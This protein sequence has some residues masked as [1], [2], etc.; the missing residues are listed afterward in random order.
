MR[1]SFDL[2]GLRR[3]IAMAPDS[4]GLNPIGLEEAFVGE[5]ALE[6]LPDAVSELVV[7][8]KRPGPVAVLSDLTPKRYRSGELLEFVT[9]LVASVASVRSVFVGAPGQNAHADEVTVAKATQD[10]EGASCLV[11]VGSGTVA[12]IGK[13]LAARHGLAY[14]VVQ[15]ANSVNGYADD[16]SVLLVSGVKRTLASCWANVLIVDVDVL[17]DAPVVM[18]AAGLADLIAMFTAPADWYLANL[19]GMDDVLAHRRGLGS[20][21]GTRPV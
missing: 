16:R 14:V 5:G 1:S 11:A 19:F 4:A 8:N 15:T 2:A 18:N 17:V 6:A 13:V 3:R 7:R 9:K 20:R 12:D 10:C 21:T